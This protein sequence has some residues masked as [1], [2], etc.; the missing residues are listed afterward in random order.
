M[1]TR[2]KQKFD[3][4]DKVA[5]VTGA[6]K[7]IGESIA[8]GLAEYGAKVVISSRNQEAVDE[9]A[10]N[11]KLDGLEAIGV[12]CH[13]GDENQIHN[14]LEQTLNIYG[15]VDILVNN[16]A[17]N[18]F[19][20]SLDTMDHALFDKIMDINV[21]APFLL[22]NKCYPIMKERGGGSI[23]N[24]SSVEGMK[25]TAG[26]ALYSMS[27]AAVI[28]LTK[29]QAVEWGKFGIR[30]NT[31]CPGLIKTKFSSAL[32]QNEKIMDQVTRHL[33]SGRMAV[34]DEMAGL[35]CFLASDASSYCTGSVFTADG[36]HMI[37]GGFS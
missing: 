14:L 37:A 35:A 9:V 33:P 13:V 11:I 3:L 5:I 27:K 7:G 23:I 24:I 1:K 17:T 32:W 28:M 21:K 2:I 22:A 15:G 19:Y 31:I 16:A 26:L 6:S 29:S 8:R 20:G 18:P 12:A 30:S 10:N 4:K 36:G 34:P 25:P